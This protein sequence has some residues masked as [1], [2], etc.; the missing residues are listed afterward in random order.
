MNYALSNT[1]PLMNCNA[2]K[3]EITEQCRGP[4]KQITVIFGQ[5][6]HYALI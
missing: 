4:I 2:D 6:L 5:R 3:S 1:G